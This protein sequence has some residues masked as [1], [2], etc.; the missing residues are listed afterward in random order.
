MSICSLDTSQI[1][2]V[3]A[4]DFIVCY[5]FQNDRIYILKSL[6]N[7]VVDSKDRRQ[8]EQRVKGSTRLFGD[9]NT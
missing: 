5:L 2:G 3:Y 4:S 1:Y 8:F 9:V 6:K 7:L